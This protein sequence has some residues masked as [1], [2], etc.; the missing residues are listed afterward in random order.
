MPS[1]DKVGRYFPLVIAHPVKDELILLDLAAT[2]DEWFNRAED[3]I[4]SGLKDDIELETFAELVSTLNLPI[5]ANRPAAL[6]RE[7]GIA[8]H[9]TLAD[10]SNLSQAIYRLAGYLMWDQKR[11]Y[12]LW[13]TTGAERIEHCLLLCTGLPRPERFSALLTGDWRRWGWEDWPVSMV[14]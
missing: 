8:W 14:P 9:C 10:L 2:D 1:V 4:L 5:W 7:D 11:S 3:V 13:W 6:K 12:S